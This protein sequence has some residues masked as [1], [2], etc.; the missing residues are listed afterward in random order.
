MLPTSRHQV[1]PYVCSFLFS[2]VSAYYCD[3]YKSRGLMATFCALLA[4]AGYALF[5]GAWFATSLA[6]DNTPEMTFLR[7]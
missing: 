2:I 7:I 6:R 5:L 3:K 4:A 1:P